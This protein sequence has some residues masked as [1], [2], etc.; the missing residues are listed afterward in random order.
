MVEHAWL[1]RNCKTSPLSQLN[2]LEKETG[3]LN[4][5]GFKQRRAGREIR[6]TSTVKRGG[7]QPTLICQTTQ[8][9]L[10]GK[11]YSLSD[12]VCFH[13]IFPSWSL[14]EPHTKRQQGPRLVTN[15]IEHFLRSW[16][17]LSTRS[18]AKGFP[19]KM[20]ELIKM[21]LALLQDLSAKSLCKIS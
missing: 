2:L 1:S 16:Q 21:S 19:A 12:P 18:L 10:H 9:Q 15:V 3:L 5:A 11:S 17:D 20:C 13:L 8:T 14:Q 6:R 4:G 7:K